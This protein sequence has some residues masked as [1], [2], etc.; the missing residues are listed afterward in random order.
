[1]ALNAARDRFAMSHE[2]VTQLQEG[3]EEGHEILVPLTSSLFVPGRIS[4]P[5]KLLIDI[6]TNYFAEKTVQGTKDYLQT[7]V[8]AVGEN[9]DSI[10]NV[11][12]QKQE[13][14]ET[15]VMVMNMRIQQ[16]Q[17]QQQRK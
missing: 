1:M 13:N 9:I 8:D 12:E 3:S 16:I 2:A 7:R 5:D 4:D 6:G 10:Q 17:Q 15:I 14:L 11:M